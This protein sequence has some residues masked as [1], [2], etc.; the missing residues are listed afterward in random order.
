MKKNIT[1]YQDLLV[2]KDNLK[3]EIDAQEFEIK[4]NKFLKFSTTIMS[5]ESIKS[6]VFDTLKSI[7][8]KE[9]ITSPIGNLLSTYL[10]S[11][12]I[13]RKYFVGFIIVKETLPYALQ[14]LKDLLDQVETK[15]D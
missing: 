4:N 12:K 11:N 7:E 15:K 5:G 2:V 14:K 13:I 1:S 3:D 8:L 9:I 6:S 10:L